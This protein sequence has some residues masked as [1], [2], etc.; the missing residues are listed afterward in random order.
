MPSRAL[1]NGESFYA[2]DLTEA[3]RKRGFVC[4]LCE[5]D[6]IIVLP[7]LDIVKHFRH[8]FKASHDWKPESQTH[9]AMKRD[10]K[11]WADSYGY[12]CELEVRVSH[13][14]IPHIADVL[15][16][17]KIVVECQC[18][19]ISIKEYEKRTK[20]YQDHGYQIIWLLGSR[21]TS[22]LDHIIEQDFFG[23][24]YYEEGIIINGLG[25]NMTLKDI[26]YL[27]SGSVLTDKREAQRAQLKAQ[28]QLRE[29]TLDNR[30]KNR[31]AREQE[32]CNNWGANG[33]FTH[34]IIYP[35]RM[36]AH[37]EGVDILDKNVKGDNPRV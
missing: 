17:G 25:E 20:F 14:D 27:T 15:I 34:P 19:Q 23:V 29:Y 12:P 30:L 6:F 21:G 7:S 1:L 22:G 16:K 35:K 3:D 2:W 36:S 26:I 10:L 18:S 13:D 8:K 11:E 9:L 31:H 28:E 24:F 37:K 5:T 33:R 4:P 32:W